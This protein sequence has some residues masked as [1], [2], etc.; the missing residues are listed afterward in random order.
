MND[1]I[2]I[3][4]S[5][6]VTARVRNLMSW[7]PS[8]VARDAAWV[9]SGNVLTG[10]VEK[11]DFPWWA[12]CWEQGVCESPFYPR[13]IPQG[14]VVRRLLSWDP[15]ERPVYDP[16]ET[17]TIGD[18]VEV[19]SYRQ[20]NGFKTI[21]RS[22]TGDLL[23]VARSTFKLHHYREWLLENFS[24]IIGDTLRISSA[25]LLQ[26]GAVAW[27][28][29]EADDVTHTSGVQLRPHLLFTTSYDGSLSSTCK[30]ATTNTVCG[31]TH[32]RALAEETPTYR[33]RHTSGSVFDVEEARRALGIL[34][35][36][37]DAWWAELD[38]LTAIPVSD[39]Q[40]SG[41]LDALQPLTDEQG[42][43]LTGRSKSLAVSKRDTLD[44][45]WRE[46]P[47][48]APWAGTAWGVEQTVNTY[49][50]HFQTVRNAARGERAVANKVAGW[51]PDA[52]TMDKLN[53]V[54]RG[55]INVAR[56]AVVKQLA[57]VARS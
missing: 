37:A 32:R 29:V 43:P 55:Q 6:E 26:G 48:C 4:P 12:G 52:D 7:D 15:I 47:R 44:S 22:D 36:E 10:M 1:T 13:E 34:E 31:N 21:R 45:L 17:V 24:A 19:V 39:G 9:A 23:H 51:T 49:A 2:T 53:V 20:A 42:E 50:T 56:S 11:Y 33:V 8:E 38:A 35:R 46:D 3:E 41:M 30:H 25:G 16:N 54:L 27:V 40:W 18:A 5:A 14:E 57:G 28:Q